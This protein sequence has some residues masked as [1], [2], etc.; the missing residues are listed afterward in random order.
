MSEPYDPTPLET[1]PEP[2]VEGHTA[3]VTPLGE[4]APTEDKPVLLG[5]DGEPIAPNPEPFGFT[6]S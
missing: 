6:P 4:P 5:P 2:I 1:T 3:E